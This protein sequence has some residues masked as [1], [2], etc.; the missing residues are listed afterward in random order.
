VAFVNLCILFYICN[1]WEKITFYNATSEES[2][3][4][5]IWILKIAEEN[6]LFISYAI[7]ELWNI[8]II[9]VCVYKYLYLFLFLH[10]GFWG[11]WLYFMLKRVWI[12]LLGFLV[13]SPL[14]FLLTTNQIHKIGLPRLLYSKKKQDFFLFKWHVYKQTFHTIES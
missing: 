1:L 10:I 14:F 5:F 11:R 4:F 3:C 8:L 9:S 7:L 13:V 2:R 6:F 12:A